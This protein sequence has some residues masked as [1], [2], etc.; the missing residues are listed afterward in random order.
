M[1]LK[2]ILALSAGILVLI[3]TIVSL[4]GFFTTPKDSDPVIGVCMGN[5]EA[6]SVYAQ[7]I[8][9]ALSATGYSPRLL[10]A[11][12]DQSRQ[13]AQIKELSEEG[14]CGL[15][16]SMVMTSTAQELTT[17]VKELDIPT[18]LISNAP[19]EDSLA[20][21]E[22]I[23]FVGCD[24]SQPGKLQAN[25]VCNL[26]NSGDIND[27]GEVSYLLLQDSP[28]KISTSLR[29]E[30]VLDS[31]VGQKLKINELG[32]ATSCENR[33]TAQN[34][35]AKY[36]AQMGKD[37][38]LIIC[39]SDEAALGAAAAVDDSGRSVGADIYIVSIGGTDEALQGVSQGLLTATIMDHQAQ[40]AEMVAQT[41]SNLIS[42]Q[43]VEKY[44]S[45]DHI[46]V[47]ADNIDDYLR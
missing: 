6:D 47:T 27:D 45:I 43:S 33:K 13:N 12:N 3:A 41:L 25:I 23:C 24:L 31:L 26:S 14:C 38:E 15:V 2:R 21:W 1:D 46:A 17:L 39:N 34:I 30:S 5:L 40:Q 32:R 20:E 19:A 16:V 29:T 28:E 7:Q 9:D 8:C 11:N 4:I 35:T 10:D 42:G 44:Y 36:L 18:V 37:I 22:R